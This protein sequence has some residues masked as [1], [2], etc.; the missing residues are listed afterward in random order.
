MTIGL[1]AL[2]VAV[3]GPGAA[4][5]AVGDLISG[6]EIENRSITDKDIAK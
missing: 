6:K 2:F 4:I 5:A 1:I 3:G